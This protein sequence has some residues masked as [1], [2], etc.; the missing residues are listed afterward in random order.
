MLMSWRAAHRCA[1][2]PG[3]A[4]DDGGR[5]RRLACACGLGLFSAQAAAL[6]VA[7]IVDNPYGPVTVQGATLAGG[8][9]SGWLTD[10]VIQLGNVPGD[11]T[12]SAQIDLADLDLPA[13]ALLTVRA[14]AAGQGVVLRNA[15]TRSS[16]I[17]GSLRFEAAYGPDFRAQVQDVN[18]LTIADGGRVVTSAT[19]TVSSLGAT[20]DRGGVL[21]NH[22]LVQGDTQLR[23]TGGRIT[24]GGRFVGSDIHVATFGHANNP[25]NGSY[26]LANGLQLWPSSGTSVALSLTHYGTSPQVLNFAINGSARVSMPSAWP[27]GYFAPSNSLP[28][29]PADVRPPGTGNPAHG[30]SGI[31]VQ[32]TG[33][34]TLGGGASNDLVLAGGVVLK[35]GGTLDLN[36]VAIVNGWTLAG[37]SFQGVNLEAPRITSSSGPI[38]VYTNN[39]NWANFSTFPYAP[40]RTWQFLAQADGSAKYVVA[41]SIAPHLNPYAALVNAAAR[42]ECWACLVDMRA[43]DMRSPADTRNDAARF[44]R[45]ATFGA[46][47]DDVEALVREGYEAWLARQ[48]ALPMVSHVATVQADPYLVDSAWYVTNQSIWKQFF[49]GQD[50]LRQRVGYALSQ[51]YVVS[52]ANGFV[53][54]SPCGAAGYLDTLNRHAFGNW[55]DLLRDV[56]LHPIMGEYLSMK[57]S[58]KSDPVLRTQPDENYAREVMQLFSIGLVQLDSD[59]TPRLDAAG[60]RIPAF[61]E[62]TVKGFAKALSGWTFGGQDQTKPWRWLYPDVWDEDP[63]LAV[64]KGCTAWT[65][66]MEPWLTSFASADGTRLI[67]G[68]AHDQGAKQ[69]LSYPGAPYATLPAKQSP[70]ADLDNALENVFRHPNVG[71]F[72]GKQLIQRLVTS[73]PSPAYVA[74]VAQA[75]ADNGSGLRGDLK[76]VVR[77][78]LLD[79]EARSLAARDAPT[80]G[81]LAE[82]VVRF[83]QLHRA[84]GAKKANGYY[85]LRGGLNAPTQLNQ[86]PLFAPSVFN[87]YHP[88][89]MPTGPLTQH[90]LVGPEFEITTSAAISGFAEFTKTDIIDGFEHGSRDPA[91]R[92]VPDYTYYSALAGDPAALVAELD[93]VLTGGAMSDDAKLRIAGSIGAIPMS[94]DVVAQGRERLRTALW[95]IANTPDYLVER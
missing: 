14:G 1:T 55:R 72:I 86:S 57:E 70:A 13:G 39:R 37:E 62:A 32:A 2:W 29:L 24:G 52:F 35:A 67:A 79:P 94:G 33:T 47:R 22:G 11:G 88:D 56:T 42:G 26:F 38:R 3:G 10:V 82:P 65:R 59:G 21:A 73:N 51:I 83:V 19:L 92:I 50:Q 41:D 34:L 90:G 84:F 12:R 17:A 25:V 75:F 89:Y 95:L 54:N 49:T 58:A 80:F 48:F 15:G 40:V 87:F 9:L 91:D 60:K 8:T 28:A 85:D 18:G 74:R 27:A 45:Q 81:R 71:P 5:A 7:T 93:L 61:S 31:I 30:A 6:G 4:V 53:A 64:Q 63:L 44:L 36:G 23:L 20:W 66:P 16:T 77:A 46:T 76:A 43:I 78:V 69:L 68:P